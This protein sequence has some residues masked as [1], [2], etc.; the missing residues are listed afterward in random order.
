MVIHE[1]VEHSNDQ[2][3]AKEEKSDVVIHDT[4]E[5][6]H[7]S[8]LVLQ[9]TSG[10]MSRSI[11]LPNADT[12]KLESQRPATAGEDAWIDAL[13]FLMYCCMDISPKAGLQKSFAIMSD[14]EDGACSLQQVYDVSSIGEA[15]CAAP[16]SDGFAG[17]SLWH[18]HHR[19]Q[20]SP[21]RRKND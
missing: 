8:Q 3:V 14:R 20:P 10:Q 17:I 12:G 16:A 11:S 1:E 19:R 7:S 21:W 15:L 18:R 9:E 5:N 2:A 6:L 4:P 13:A